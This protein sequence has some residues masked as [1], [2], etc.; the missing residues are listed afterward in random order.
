MRLDSDP[1]TSPT[2]TKQPR[3]ESAGQPRNARLVLSGMQAL[4]LGGFYV[5]TLIY[6]SIQADHFFSFSNT[7]NIL[8]NVSV[9]GIVTLGQMLVL[10]AGG[11]DLSVG[12]TL[13]LGGV[14]FTIL[15]NHGVNIPESWLI[16]TLSGGAVGAANG[17]I[18]TRIGINPLV[19]TLGTLSVTAGLANLVTA[20]ETVPF[21]DLN[22]GAVDTIV[23]G[24]PIYIGVWLTIT[25]LVFIV[26]RFTVFGRMVYAIGGN[27]E[28]S[29][30]AG[31]RVDL[32]TTL[33]YVISGALAAFSG[34]VLAQ[35]L[36][37][38]APS[39]GSTAALT[40]IAAVILGGAAL[41]GGVGGVP[42]TVVGVLVLGTVANGLALMQVPAF[43][44][45][46]ATGSI[47]LLAVGFGRLRALFGQLGDR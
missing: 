16:A 20:G 39:V 45:Q 32:I 26:L 34:V 19:T 24:V 14:V 36:L 15:I 21:N 23:A 47:L 18:I 10:I 38:G 30:L 3:S 46:I 9:I 25:L 37:A 29:R 5:I 7:I 2:P 44:Q 41:T 28:A 6:F 12:G 17:L 8:S 42:G 40:S 22:A 13:P 35:Q 11:F 4:G 33:V 27:R 1:V 31:I 43:Y